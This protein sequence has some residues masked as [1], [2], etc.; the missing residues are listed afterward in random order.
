M[1]RVVILLQQNKSTDYYFPTMAAWGAQIENRGHLRLSPPIPDP[2]HDRNAWVHFKMG[3][4]PAATV[5][6]DNDVV[7][8]YYSWLAKQFTFCD[9]HF[10]LG[11]NSTSGHMFVVGGQS[12]TLRNPPISSTW[13]LPTIFKLAE[14]AGHSWGAF[15][16]PDRYPLNYYVE[17]GDAASLAHTFTST[18]PASDRFIAMATQR[19]L[20]DFCLVW[21]PPGYDEHPPDSA[22]DPNY[23]KK[24]HDLTWARVDAVV[25]AGDWLD[26]VFILTWDD[27]GGY[28]DHVS[29]PNAETVIDDL[30][31]NGFQVIGGS[32]IPLIMFGGHIKQGIESEWHSHASLPKT[33]IDLLQLPK[34]GV[35]RVDTSP[36]LQGR[37]DAT[38]NRPTPPAF[39]SAIVQPPAPHPTPVPTAPKAWRG[40]N[41][42]PLSDLV[43]NAGKTIPAPVDGATVQKKPPKLAPGLS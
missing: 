5:Q 25:R 3:D 35:P 11:T 39:G 19:A 41:M 33:V 15:T 32:R 24:G 23:V 14:R 1:S 37:V 42:K 27:W 9:H 4:Y 13:D 17:L 6:I 21:S 18:D 28:A 8:P 10:G 2:P 12:P 36:S 31:P 22:P 26:T 40:A 20:P 16:G 7:I 34:F 29:T 38:L 30:H 43:A